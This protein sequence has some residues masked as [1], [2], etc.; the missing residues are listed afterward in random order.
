MTDELDAITTTIEA[1]G[2][3]G[4]RA[5]EV[6]HVDDDPPARWFASAFY[7]GKRVSCDNQPNPLAAVIGLYA[8]LAAGGLCIHCE[9]T[10]AL[11]HG[12][13][14]L[15][16][17]ARMSGGVFQSRRA[18]AEPRAYCVRRIGA[19]WRCRLG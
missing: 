6:G 4:A 8:I 11:E 19:G 14:G 12:E 3:T 15:V 1:V 10:I 5:M 9:R 2:R 7:Q 17:G 16:D 13:V 18:E